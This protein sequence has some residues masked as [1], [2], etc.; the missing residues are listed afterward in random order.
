[1]SPGIESTVDLKLKK[2]VSLGQVDSLSGN[3]FIQENLICE[4]N[5]QDFLSKG[6]DQKSWTITCTIACSIFL[7]TTSNALPDTGASGYLFTSRVMTK[8][9]LKYSKPRRVTDFPPSL[10]A[11]FYGKATQLIDIALIMNLKNDGSKLVNV[12]F[13]LINKKHDPVLR[14]KWF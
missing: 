10:I 11:G 3:D 4:T 8:R 2:F 13:L 6:L 5:D 14:R 1:M 7:L 9:A 12:Q